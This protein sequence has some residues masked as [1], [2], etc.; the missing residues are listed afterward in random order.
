MSAGILLMM[1]EREAGRPIA[2]TSRV[3]RPAPVDPGLEAPWADRAAYYVR[4]HKLQCAFGFWACCVGG[5]L[6]ASW[7]RPGS[8][9]LKVIHARVYAQGATLL[10]LGLGAAVTA[11]DDA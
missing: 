8:T 6:A 3:S 4:T 11:L 5:A 7:S 2:G 1:A 10:A 9:Q